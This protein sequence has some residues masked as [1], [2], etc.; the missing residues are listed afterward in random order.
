MTAEQ[1]SHTFVG[2]TIG[3]GAS[4]SGTGLVFG[5]YEVTSTEN[6]DWIV[7]SEFNEIEFISASTVAA[8]VWTAEPVTVDGTIKNKIVLHAGGTDTIRMLIGGT[9]A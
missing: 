6:G 4:N 2:A 3:A 8:G 1:L 5:L 9:P 7:L